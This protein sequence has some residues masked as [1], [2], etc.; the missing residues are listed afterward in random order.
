MESHP[1]E[2]YQISADQNESKENVVLRALVGDPHRH[3]PLAEH[4][5]PSDALS[6]AKL[7]ASMYTLETR[8]KPIPQRVLPQSAHQSHALIHSEAQHSNFN[9]LST[10]DQNEP[11]RLEN[12]EKDLQTNFVESQVVSTPILYTLVDNKTLLPSIDEATPQIIP[13]K[14]E[15]IPILYN[16]IGNAR[17]QVQIQEPTKLPVIPSIVSQPSASLYS[18]IGN[19]GPIPTIVEDKIDSSKP[20]R[21]VAPPPTPVKKPNDDV[22]MY[23]VIGQPQVPAKTTPPR[24]AKSFDTTPNKPVETPT[25]YTL[26]SKPRSPKS[27]NLND[28]AKR[29]DEKKSP[30][31]VIIPLRLSRSLDRKQPKQPLAPISPAKTKETKNKEATIPKSETIFIPMRDDDRTASRP[32]KQRSN[33]SNS[34]IENPDRSPFLLNHYEP[35]RL[36]DYQ[37]PYAYS[38]QKA[39]KERRSKT[40]ILPPLRNVRSE[41]KSRHIPSLPSNTPHS[42]ERNP[43]DTRQRSRIWDYEYETHSDGDGD[44]D[45]D[46]ETKFE[47]KKRRY[48]RFRPRTPWVPVW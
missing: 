21:S 20:V 47:R 43:V 46:Y 16:L 38:P 35:L 11:N 32:K 9:D 44:E 30:P 39:T 27:E 1:I 45:E 28:R 17:P 22:M 14:T 4:S 31:P 33:P 40:I 34:T 10:T 7:P 13:K 24:K 3:K 48:R 5:P 36:R 37:S 19:P 15:N 25:F 6:S 23:A 12:D 29:S 8:H 26:V 42:S 2:V 18:I 41:R